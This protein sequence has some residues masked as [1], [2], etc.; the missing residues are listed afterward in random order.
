MRL[1]AANI[2]RAAIHTSGQDERIET[3]S[4]PSRSLTPPKSAINNQQGLISHFLKWYL[5]PKFLVRGAFQGRVIPFVVPRL[6]RIQ[7]KHR[8]SFRRDVDRIVPGE[9]TVT[10]K[11]KVLS[12]QIRDHMHSHTITAIP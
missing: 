1:T 5:R 6:E 3:L 8:Q 2:T 11:G 7:A 9:S 4:D 10:R 12:S